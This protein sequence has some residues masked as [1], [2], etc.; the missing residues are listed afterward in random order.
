[1]PKYPKQP[2]VSYALDPT[3]RGAYAVVMYFPCGKTAFGCPVL[4]GVQCY[5]P[6]ELLVRCE[7]KISLTAIQ[8]L[9]ERKAYPVGPQSLRASPRR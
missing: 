7:G 3:S 6:A 5:T 4:L 2:A 1:M 8:V 9:D